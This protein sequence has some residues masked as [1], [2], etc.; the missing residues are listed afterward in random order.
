MK[1][2]IHDKIKVKF[3]L[4]QI[5]SHLSII[6]QLWVKDNTMLKASKR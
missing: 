5:K 4:G 1:N 6:E 2:D 3:K